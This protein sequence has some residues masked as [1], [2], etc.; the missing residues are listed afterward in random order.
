M[1][2]ML[3]RFVK[4]MYSPSAQSGTEL[5]CLVVASTFPCCKEAEC[6]ITIIRPSLWPEEIPKE[7]HEYLDGLIE[8]WERTPASEI[9][10][11][12]EQ[13]SHLSIGPLRQA[14]AGYCAPESIQTIGVE[15]LGSPQGADTSQ[16]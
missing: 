2:E 9:P 13:L 15:F 14:E 8:D 6:A 3:C 11:L 1:S 10:I 7:H 12:L 16:L 4:I 5:P